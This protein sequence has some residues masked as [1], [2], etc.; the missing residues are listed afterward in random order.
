IQKMVKDAE[1]HA[2]EDKQ[3]RSLAEAKNETETL[4]YSLEKAITDAGDKLS[5][6]DKQ[7]AEDE[8]KRAREAL[9][10]ENL[11]RINAAKDAISKVANQLSSK[12]YSGDAGPTG[13]DS[14]APGQGPTGGEKTAGNAGSGEKVVD[15]DYTVVDDDK[16]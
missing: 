6:S 4:T 15:A 3:A 1:A 2:Q 7:L 13:G 5:A 14:G 12:I 16:K 8:I 10:S 11:E 9:A